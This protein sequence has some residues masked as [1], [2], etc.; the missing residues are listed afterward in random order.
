[1][2]GLRP[3]TR[4]AD[5]RPALRARLGRRHAAHDDVV[6]VEELPVARGGSRLDLAVI[7]GRIEGFE[8]KSAR[9]TL[10]RLRRQVALGS[11]AMERA[12]LVAAPDHIPEALHL[13]P[14][15]WSVVLA[16]MGPR[17]AIHFRQYRR[18]GMN[19]QAC[20]RAFVDMLERKE[21]VALL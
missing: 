10:D 19:P 17:G 7:N 21:I 16:E 9:D 15:W 8:I 1:M 4:D 5:I 12:T 6:I 13:L 18:G 11:P 2:N 20:P 3:T 14:D